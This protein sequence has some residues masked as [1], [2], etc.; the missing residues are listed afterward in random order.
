MKYSH[1]RGDP[2]PRCRDL[3]IWQHERPK[4]CPHC[5][6]NIELGELSR[7]RDAKTQG[8]RDED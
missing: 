4:R 1:K 6:Y 7:A 2:C 8:P 5:G 3:I